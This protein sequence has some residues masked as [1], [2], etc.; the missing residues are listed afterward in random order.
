MVHLDRLDVDGARPAAAAVVVGG[1]HQRETAERRIGLERRDGPL[2]P[3]GL[4][5]ERVV[6]AYQVVALDHVE[7]AVQTAVRAVA[8]AVVELD[9]VD[10]ATEVL[11][12]EVRGHHLVGVVG[13]DHDR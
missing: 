11:P 2:Q 4:E 3:A 1:L 12:H 9:R 7:G 10:A 6:H 13:E 8:V 5:L